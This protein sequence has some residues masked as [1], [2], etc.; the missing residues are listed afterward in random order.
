[1]NTTAPIKKDSVNCYKCSKPIGYYLGANAYTV[2]CPE[3]GTIYNGY[4]GTLVRKTE[5]AKRAV[6]I[7]DIPFGAN[8]TIKGIRYLVVGF[9]LKKEK[10]T[11]YSWH[12][13]TL[14]NPVHGYA[15]LAQYAGH[16]TYLTELERFP[17]EAHYK[18]SITYDNA[19]YDIYARYKAVTDK[20]AGEF[21]YNL[22][23]AETPSVEEFINPPYILTSEKTADEQVW[24]KGEYMGPDDIKKAFGLEKIPERVGIGATQPFV[25][26]FSNE[27]FKRLLIMIT[28]LFGLV[29]LFFTFTAKEELAFD[30]SYYIVDS[31]NKK[32]I[33]STPFDLKYGTKNVEVALT[34]NVDNNWMYTGV[35][36]VN[37][38][39]GDVYDVDLDAEYYH[40]YEGGEN[41]SEGSSKNSI[42]I[43]QVPE[44]KYY[45]IIYPDKPNVGKTM[46]I[47]LT[48]TRDVP[49]FSNVLIVIL[50]LAIFPAIYFYRRSS[51]ERK[52]WDN[53]NYSPYDSYDE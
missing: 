37:Q 7:Q 45:L 26:K 5:A 15:T 19:V 49:I 41:W 22:N 38:T 40:G 48:V 29:Q 10:G 30:G 42:V 53:S 47:Q 21:P 31:T 12:E 9:A 50:L 35:T 1:M 23:L 18:K 20:V 34:A 27:A 33:F 36:L 28:I 4:T 51:F 11:N 25:G 44:G 16:W 24:F 39:T 43:S 46:R 32:E 3:C 8:G 17:A 6:D 52:R 13:Y 14:F 2:I